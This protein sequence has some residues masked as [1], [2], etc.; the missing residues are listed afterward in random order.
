METPLI[1]S[2]LLLQILLTLL[3]LALPFIIAPAKIVLPLTPRLRFPVPPI[4]ALLVVQTVIIPRIPA[5]TIA[6]VIAALLIG[7]LSLQLLT[8]SILLLRLY[9]SLPF[10]GPSLVVVATLPI[11]ILWIIHATLRFILAPL[12]LEQPLLFLTLSLLIGSSSLLLGLSFLIETAAVFLLSTL[13]LLIAAFLFSTSLVGNSSL[14]FGL[15]FLIETAAILLLLILE[16]GPSLLLTSSFRFSALL[17]LPLAI[18][19]TLLLLRLALAAAT[20]LISL[21]ALLIIVIAW[22]LLG[23]CL[24]LIV[25]LTLV[26]ATAPIVLGG[27]EANGSQTERYNQCETANLKIL[28]G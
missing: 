7:T 18:R 27:D 9:S 26:M 19:L 10:Q 15:S 1:Y 4:R 22:L 8:L 16:L 23:C 12:L 28:H 20:L 11:L 17:I 14:F 3:P 2:S 6:W 24:L 25:R 13:H 21:P 5:E